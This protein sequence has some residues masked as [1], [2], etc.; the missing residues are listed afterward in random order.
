MMG[1][2]VF[3]EHLKAFYG[4]YSFII[5]P[6]RKFALAM[7]VFLM[8]NQNLGFMSALKNPAVLVFLSLLCAFFPLSVLTVLAALV[9]LLHLYSLSLE[10]AA[11]TGILVLCAAILYSSFQ[12]GNSILMVLMPLLFFIRIPYAAP[13]IVG[14]SCGLSALIPMSFGVFIYYL[15][16]YA[17]QNAG[18]L[19]GSGTIDITQKYMQILKSLFSNEK[20]L[21]MV[22]AFLAAAIVVYLIRN[23][24]LS[25]AWSIAIA[26][27][28]VVEL[29]VIFIGNS[30]MGVSLSI[31]SIAVSVLV[32]VILAFVFQFFVFAVDYSRTEFLQFQDDDYYYYVKAVPKVAVSTPD[33]KVQRINRRKE[34]RTA[35]P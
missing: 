3:K 34:E 29:A 7:L 24:S 13:L 2:L 5:N 14:L 31:G 11:V 1:L 18:V 35:E 23:L 8:L 25:Y 27:G 19:A 21:I 17:K 10:L 16:M 15:V 4:R 6:L 26:A 20:M 12:P 22:A 28:T 33:I 30:R 32:S 9:M